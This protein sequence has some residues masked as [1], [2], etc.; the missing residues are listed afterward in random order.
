LAVDETHGPLEK[1]S[2][3]HVI[4]GAW[5]RFVPCDGNDRHSGPKAVED[6]RAA[7]KGL[8]VLELNRWEAYAGGGL[9]GGF[10]RSPYEN[11][12]QQSLKPRRELI[13]TSESWRKDENR[14]QKGTNWCWKA[15]KGGSFELLTV[16]ENQRKYQ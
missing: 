3:Q 15:K 6:F 8:G 10:T 2:E 11:P 16:P 5:E 7:R 4:T 12:N 14:C 13:K 9:W 1:T